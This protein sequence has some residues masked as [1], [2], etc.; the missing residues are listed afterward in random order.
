MRGNR[1]A[2]RSSRSVA[3]TVRW[4]GLALAKASGQGRDDASQ[5]GILSHL[6]LDLANRADDGRVIF[7]AEATADLGIAHR[8]ELARKIHGNHTWMRDS[9]MALGSFEVVQLDLEVR[10][11]LA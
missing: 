10:R 6:L 1:R 8:G 3:R 11:D 4:P 2:S 9:A 7:S 5:A